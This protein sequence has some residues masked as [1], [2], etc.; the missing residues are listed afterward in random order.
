MASEH[1]AINQG[2]NLLRSF[3]PAVGLSPDESGVSRLGET[4]TPVINVW[5]RPDLA[6]LRGDRQCSGN[7]DPAAGAGTFASVS[8]LNPA[9]SGVIAII[10]SITVAASVAG[11]VRVV[12]RS[13]IGGVPGVGQVGFRD[14]RWGGIL[15]PVCVMRSTAAAIPPGQRLHDQLVPLNQT[16]EILVTPL[17]IPPDTPTGQGS[18][19]IV[20]TTVTTPQLFVNIKWTE[21]LALPG[22]LR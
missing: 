6:F 14:Q 10:E 13:P 16:V 18:F 19:N 3:P 22:E 20:H 8:F 5:T 2:T 7:E 12:G 11:L 9:G 21:R 15:A 17:I 1:N 4:L